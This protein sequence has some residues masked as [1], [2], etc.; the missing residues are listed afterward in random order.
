MILILVKTTRKEILRSFQ[1]LQWSNR[2]LYCIRVKYTHWFSFW[3]FF[4]KIL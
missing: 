3:P 2:I 4:T 1:L